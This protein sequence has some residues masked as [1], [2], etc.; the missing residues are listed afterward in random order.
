MVL[1]NSSTPYVTNG[2]PG[3]GADWN[4]TGSPE[5]VITDVVGA[6]ARR[7]D[8]GSSTT[9]YIKESGTGN[10]GWRAV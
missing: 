1:L 8:G 9:F 6:T 2:I 10:T 5:G 3:R 4:L 7:R